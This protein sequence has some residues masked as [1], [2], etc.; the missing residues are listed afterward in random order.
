MLKS[1]QHGSKSQF[2][3]VLSYNVFSMKMVTIAGEEWKIGHVE[4]ADDLCMTAFSISSDQIV[5]FEF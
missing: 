5:T 1:I 4:N 3:S 2:S